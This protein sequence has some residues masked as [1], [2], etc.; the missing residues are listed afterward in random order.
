MD[1]GWLEMSVSSQT[2]MVVAETTPTAVDLQ[3]LP[4]FTCDTITEF[5]RSVDIVVHK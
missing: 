4:Q 3:Q 1:S 2:Q 5:K